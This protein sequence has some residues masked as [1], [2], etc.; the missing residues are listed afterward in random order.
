M[1]R[2][3]SSAAILIRIL[4]SKMADAASGIKLTCGRQADTRCRRRG[5]QLSEKLGVMARLANAHLYVAFRR[6]ELG[7]R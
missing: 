5:V 7:S 6:T 1:W 4:L 2:C 3:K